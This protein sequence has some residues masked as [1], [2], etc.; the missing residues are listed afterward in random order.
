MIIRTEIEKRFLKPVLK[1]KLR[2]WFPNQFSKS[3]PRSSS[4]TDIISNNFAFNLFCSQAV[5]EHTAELLIIY[6]TTS[7]YTTA[8]YKFQRTRRNWPLNNA[9][10]EVVLMNARQGCTL[11]SKISCLKWPKISDSSPLVWN[12]EIT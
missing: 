7:L 3:K 8:L 1:S 12:F 2:N 9:P 10:P 6:W 11:T 4:S 5:D